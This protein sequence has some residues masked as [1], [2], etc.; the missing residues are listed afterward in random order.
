LPELDDALCNDDATRDGVVDAPCPRFRGGLGVG[1]GS[2]RGRRGGGEGIGEGVVGGPSHAVRRRGGRGGEE[3]AAGGEWG[4]GK[5][6]GPGAA[7]V[8]REAEDG[9]G[10]AEHRGDGVGH[11]TRAGFGRFRRG[12]R[13]VVRNRRV[14]ARE[15]EWA[16]PVRRGCLFCLSLFLACRNPKGR[17]LELDLS[18]INR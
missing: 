2:G 6:R 1:G 16:A 18:N 5:A 9:G 7:E 15:G 11:R 10:R 13:R 4:A 17:M 3:A 8:A 12:V 14:P